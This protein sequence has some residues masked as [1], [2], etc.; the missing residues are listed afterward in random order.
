MKLMAL[1][2]YTEVKIDEQV[3]YFQNN[4]GGE[5]FSKQFAKYLKSKDIHHKF[6]NPNIPQENNIAKYINHILFSTI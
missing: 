1:I 5:Y 6:T 4:D 2:K 3:N